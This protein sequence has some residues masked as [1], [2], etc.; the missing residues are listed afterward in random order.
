[1]VVVRNP[2]AISPTQS[3]PHQ[4]I[5]LPCHRCLGCV[6]RNI[7][8]DVDESDGI[9]CL[10]YPPSLDRFRWDIRFQKSASR[11]LTDLTQ[12]PANEGS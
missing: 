1:M 3:L 2:R 10:F 4:E 8:R 9:T 7:G 11:R 5:C 6:E 12:Q